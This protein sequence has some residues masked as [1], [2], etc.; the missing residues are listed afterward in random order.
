MELFTT[1]GKLIF[2]LT[3]KDVRCVHHGCHGTHRYDFQVLVTHASTWMYRF[4][5][6]L[7]RS[8]LQ[9][10]EVTWQW[11]EEFSVFDISLKKKITGRN[12][13]GPRGP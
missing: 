12:A 13:R 5:S 10:S 1:K 2:F 6:L 4:S 8:V 3:T 9:V 7:R 11:W